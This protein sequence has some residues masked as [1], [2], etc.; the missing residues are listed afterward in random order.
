MASVI[1]V[2]KANLKVLGFPDFATW[3]ENP[4]NV[5]IGRHVQ[6][7]DGT[8]SSKWRNPFSAKQYG[9][10]ECIKKYERH[11]ITSGLINNIHELRGKSLG[12]WCKPESCHGDILVKYA[13]A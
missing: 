6:Y 11:L 5:Y 10:E 12:C 1:C 9:R 13:N 2:K 8:Y 4:N 7:V 3:N